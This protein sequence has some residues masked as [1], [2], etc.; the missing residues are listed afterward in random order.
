[1]ATDVILVFPGNIMP[2][3]IKTDTSDY[4]LGTEIKQF[5]QP[6]GCYSHK[7]NNVQKNYTAIQKGF[8]SVVK[9]LQ[10]EILVMTDPKNLTHKFCCLQCSIL[11]NGNCYLKNLDPSLSIRKVLRTALCTKI[12]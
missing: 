3:I 4:K 9:T 12:G 1:M 6:V 2:F 7:L 5:G 10:A 8:L 11:F